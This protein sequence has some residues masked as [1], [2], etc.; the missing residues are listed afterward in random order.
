MSYNSFLFSKLTVILDL[1]VTI[2]TE[3]FSC[4]RTVLIDLS[5]LVTTL[6]LLVTTI[7]SLWLKITGIEN[8]HDTGKNDDKNSM[9]YT[10]INAW[11]FFI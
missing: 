11:F 5:L 8:C 9:M 10:R 2:A 4:T 1:K 7:K 6:V 3:N